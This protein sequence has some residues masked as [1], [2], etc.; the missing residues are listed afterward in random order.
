MTPRDKSAN[1]IGTAFGRM[2]DAMARTWTAKPHREGESRF[3]IDFPYLYEMLSLA[4]R[5]VI[6]LQEL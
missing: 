3:Y 5:V 6:G 2:K 1:I 4:E